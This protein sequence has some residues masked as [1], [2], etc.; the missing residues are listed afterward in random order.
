MSR[1]SREIIESQKS[2]YQEDVKKREELLRNQGLENKII[3]KDSI[4]KSL[5]GK[6][7]QMN[8]RYLSVCA[9]ENRSKTSKSSKKEDT[10]I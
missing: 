7:R 8:Q 6:G 2:Y 9:S 4:L 3:L 1:Q 10:E 5:K